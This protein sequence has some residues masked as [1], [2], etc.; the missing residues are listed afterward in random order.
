[1]SPEFTPPPRCDDMSADAPLLARRLLASG[2]TQWELCRRPATAELGIEVKE[3]PG[4][5]YGVVAARSFSKGERVIA[6]EPLAVWSTRGVMRPNEDLERCVG[7]LDEERWHTFFGLADIY[8]GD[9]RGKTVSGIWNTNSF[10]T[11]DVLGD[12]N[13][14]ASNG[15]RRTAVFGV[16]SRFKWVRLR[17]SSPYH[18]DRGPLA[19]LGLG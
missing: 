18:G 15:L 1:M 17:V 16:C 13:S 9:G 10:V 2:H 19:R 12:G 11:E 14:Q 3:F 4:R 8:S 6:E 5:G 7:Q